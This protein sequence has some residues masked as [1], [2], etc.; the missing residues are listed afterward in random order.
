MLFVCLLFVVV[1][2]VV[3]YL[4]FIYCSEKHETKHRPEFH[5]VLSKDRIHFLLIHGPIVGNCT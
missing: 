3:V 2:V 1:V 5:K 4:L